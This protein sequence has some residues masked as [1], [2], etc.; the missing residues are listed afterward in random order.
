MA[1][2]GNLKEAYAKFAV[3]NIVNLCIFQI[4][5]MIDGIFVG[6]Y[7]GEQALAGVNLA[8][9]LMNILYCIAITFSVGTG[10]TVAERV[11]AG[12]K[13]EASEL[14]SQSIVFVSAISIVFAAMTAISIRPLC[15]FLGAKGELYEPTSEYLL[16]LAAFIPFIVIEYD[17]E[18]LIKEDGKQIPCMITVI[19]AQALNV[20]LDWIFIA[21]A[22]WGVAGAALATGIAQLLTCAV[23]AVM[24]RSDKRTLFRFSFALPEFKNVKRF[25]F[26]GLS[27]GLTELCV[28]VI[29]WLYNIITYELFGNI[30]VSLFAVIAYVNSL[31]IN[32]MNGAG[33]GMEPL[34]GYYRGGKDFANCRKLLRYGITVELASAVFF[35]SAIFLF[36]PCIVKLFL[37]DIGGETLVAAQSWIRHY[38]LS[39]IPAA[40]SLPTMS[41]FS[42]MNE[43]I[44]AVAVSVGRGALV[45][46]LILLALFAVFRSDMIWWAS[47]ISESIVMIFSFVLINSKTKE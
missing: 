7:V 40:V 2:D 5:S 39:Y 46:S 32:F 44:Y 14:F 15:T 24:I 31:I 27:D 16:S 37:P 36:A 30:G 13:E 47:L 28:A 4:Y 26:I 45:H 42:A 41:Y 23:F 1:H 25:F 34:V 10:I 21:K 20:L 3:P 6:N 9:P 8:I 29:L 35:A 18:Y 33:L 17:L 38:A 22:E 43:P 12:K 19:C 11:G